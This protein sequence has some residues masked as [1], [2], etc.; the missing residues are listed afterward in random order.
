MPAS[1][2]TAVRKFW[3]LNREILDPR[4][5]TT[6]E[7]RAALLR[8]QQEL[9]AARRASPGASAA[10]AAAS[11]SPAAPSGLAPRGDTPEVSLEERRVLALEAI[12]AALGPVAEAA[13]LYIVSK[14]TAHIGYVSP[15]N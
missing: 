7:W 15:A 1:A 9:R 4:A 5:P 2:R 13:R 3:D 8:A 11:P 12:A 14:D 10:A 6:D